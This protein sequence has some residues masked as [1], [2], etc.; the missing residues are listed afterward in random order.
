MSL[1]FRVFSV[2]IFL[3]GILLLHQ[4]PGRT[5][6]EIKNYWNTRIKRRQ[7]AGLPLYPPDIQP[8]DP[9][10]QTQQPPNGDT[11]YDRVPPHDQLLLN[12]KPE[13]STDSFDRLK[14][15]N[16]NCPPFSGLTD[17]SM[18]SMLNQAYGMG[19]PI[20]RLKRIRDNQ[21]G[22]FFTG[23]TSS[24][25]GQMVDDGRKNMQ[26]CFRPKQ[27]YSQTAR[28]D[29]VAQGFPYDPDPINKILPPF[30][31]ALT[32]S[33]ALINGTFS[34]SRPFPDLKLELPS[35]QFAESVNTTGT[36]TPVLNMNSPLT[37]SSLPYHLLN[38]ADACFSPSNSGLLESL[39]QEAHTMGG[40]KPPSELPAVSSGSNNNPMNDV[41]TSQR[42]FGWGENSDPTTPLDG[43]AA[44]VFS[45]STP[46]LSNGPW[47]E[48]SLHQSP[49][50]MQF[51]LLP[52]FFFEFCLN[53]WYNISKENELHEHHNESPENQI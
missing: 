24:P 7:R 51:S 13:I 9:N 53:L 16:M 26:P 30:G 12:S 37:L 10:Q 33:H 41:F 1:I 6:N 25:C 5:D 19:N 22:S 36:G 21:C 17:V 47:D 23:P 20:Q 3:F 52:I 48:S 35:S 50:G 28:W 15:T 40:I 43:R 8:R 38:K 4:L 44:S 27:T 42:K 32:G 49:N 46:P 31:G 29:A 14:P 45:E 2:T 11:L 39:L 34:A 18:N